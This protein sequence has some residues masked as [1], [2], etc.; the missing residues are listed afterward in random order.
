MP[1]LVS[2]D[3]DTLGFDDVGSFKLLFLVSLKDLL[4]RFL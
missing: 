3:C 2:F 1:V 4:S